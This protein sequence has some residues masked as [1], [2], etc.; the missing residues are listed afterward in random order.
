VYGG[1]LTACILPGKELVQVPAAEPYIV[2]R[3]D[4]IMK[5]ARVLQK[6]GVGGRRWTDG[7][8]MDL[9]EIAAGEGMEGDEDGGTEGEQGG[10]G[11]RQ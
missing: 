2:N 5:R 10:R 7:E 6:E 9:E 3:Y 11:R 1:N 8:E 4:R